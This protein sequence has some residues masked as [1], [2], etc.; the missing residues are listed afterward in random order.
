MKSLGLGSDIKESGNIV[1]LSAWGGSGWSLELDNKLDNLN[2]NIQHTESNKSSI[3]IAHDE[4]RIGFG[5]GKIYL[6]NS[7]PDNKEGGFLFVFD[8]MRV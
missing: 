5:T 6:T 8:Y 2:L 7:Y 4:L 1:T 3:C